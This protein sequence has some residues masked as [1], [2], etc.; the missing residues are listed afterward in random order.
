[1]SGRM[2]AFE[3]SGGSAEWPILGGIADRRV[4]PRAVQP[5]LAGCQLAASG[6]EGRRAD[7]RYVTF[8]PLL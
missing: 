5:L 8:S 6:I 3:I 7:M 2:A 1:L 4:T